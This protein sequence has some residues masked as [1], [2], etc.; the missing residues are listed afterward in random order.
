MEGVRALDAQV[1][2][3]G[4]GLSGLVAASELAA[5]GIDVA[6]VEA[7]ERVGGRTLNQPLSNGNVVEGG[8]EWMYPFHEK[9][10]TLAGELE[11]ETFA[12]YDEGDRVSFF[13]NELT[14]YDSGYIPLDETGLEQFE[15]TA[16]LLDELSAGID[17]AA[18][19]DAD[20]ADELDAQTFDGWLRDR[21]D[22][23]AARSIFDTTFGLNF[24]A[25]LERVSLLFALSY[26]AG[27]GASWRN[28][29]PLERYR[30][31]GG[32][33]ILSTKLAD[34]LGQRVSLGSPVTRVVQ[35]DGDSVDVVGETFRICASNCIVALSPSDCRRIH[36]EPLLPS[37]RRILQDSW[38]SGPQIKAHAVYS[39]PFWREAG[40]SGFARSDLAPAPVVFDNSPADGSEA[41]LISLFQQNP[42]PTRDGLTN[43]VADS[44]D[45]RREAVLSAL[46]ALFGPE[47][48]S[49]LRFFEQN[50]QDEP[51]NSGCQPFYPPG[52]LT[53]TREAIRQ[54]CGRV[55]WA[56]TETAARCV[57]WME[58]AIDAGQ[59]ASQEVMA[60]L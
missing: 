29:F 39:K 9:V 38:Q 16:G 60:A 59:R 21:I 54:P 40:L 27:F 4:A 33:Q 36:F 46:A 56:G 48:A 3:V 50:W 57:G 5:A 6:V 2:I 20:G 11:I 30:F 45:L 23:P 10:A 13:Q 28:I 52:L 55:H 8:G 14:R 18:P 58:G 26:V 24:G 44:V 25:P 7:K 1:V 42:G 19:W 17:P 53:G 41:V 34:Q 47:A 31:Q 49:P 22:D 32:S 43:S 12:Q 37:R 51:F 35:G 15:A